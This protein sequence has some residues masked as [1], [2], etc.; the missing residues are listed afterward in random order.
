MPLLCYII[1]DPDRHLRI[2][3]F[4]KLAGDSGYGAWRRD[5]GHGGAEIFSLV[6]VRDRT[7]GL[8][9]F[10]QFLLLPIG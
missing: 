7:D 3:S 8:N 1:F 6:W 5:W 10:A 2:L 4:F 9:F